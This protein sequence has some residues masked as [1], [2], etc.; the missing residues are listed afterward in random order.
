MFADQHRIEASLAVT[1]NGNLDFDLTGEYALARRA[2]T[3]VPLPPARVSPCS[4]T[5]WWSDLAAIILFSNAPRIPSWFM[6]VTG[7]LLAS[8]S[9]MN[10]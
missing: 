2:V 5:R 3:V 9:S 6:T 10:A 7:F 1:R 4:W 8:S